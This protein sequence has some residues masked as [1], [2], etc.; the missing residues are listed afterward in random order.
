MDLYKQLRLDPKQ[1]RPGDLLNAR[2]K[3]SKAYLEKEKKENYAK[4]SA[5]EKAHEKRESKIHEIAEHLTKEQVEALK[6]LVNP[7]NKK[8]SKDIKVKIMSLI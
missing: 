1:V 8:M 4:M 2:S 6:K 7:K 3:M 5:K